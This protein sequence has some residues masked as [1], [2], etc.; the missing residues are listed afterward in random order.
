MAQKT[1]KERHIA[2]ADGSFQTGNCPW[3]VAGSGVSHALPP[4][5]VEEVGIKVE[6]LLGGANRF[7]VTTGSKEQHGTIIE[8]DRRYGI[9]L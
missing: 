8:G 5:C 3:E 4:Y 9:Q 2:H 1:P 7:V 6:R